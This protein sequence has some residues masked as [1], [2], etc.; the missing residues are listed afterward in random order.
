VNRTVTNVGPE[1]STYTAKVEVSKSLNIQVTPDK[2][3]FSKAGEKK[4]FSISVSRKLGRGERK[5]ESSSMRH[6]EGSLSW[7]SRKHVVRSPI[8]ASTLLSP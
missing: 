1:T 6:I 8:A 7:V 2:L 5:E 4:M 3:V